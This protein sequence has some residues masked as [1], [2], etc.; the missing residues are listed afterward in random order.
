[1]R[2]VG[3]RG[4]AVVGADEGDCVQANGWMWPVFWYVEAYVFSM[5]H[6]TNMIKTGF[7]GIPGDPGLNKT[8]INNKQHNQKIE[9]NTMTP[10]SPWHHR[11]RVSLSPQG[12]QFPR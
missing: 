6:L 8:D 10:W 5:L 4:G 11:G 3:A 9:Q 2:A 1:M 7:V 12:A